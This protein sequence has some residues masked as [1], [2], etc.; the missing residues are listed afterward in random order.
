MEFSFGEFPRLLGRKVRGR[1]GGNQQFYDTAKVCYCLP[2]RRDNEESAV[3]FFD[4]A[5]RFFVHQGKRSSG[6]N[7]RR[8]RGAGIIL[9]VVGGEER[10]DRNRYNEQKTDFLAR[11]KRK[12]NNKMQPALCRVEKVLLK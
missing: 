7:R 12:V 11:R 8:R 5:D 2:F 3:R 9:E 4:V 1:H 6:S 10:W